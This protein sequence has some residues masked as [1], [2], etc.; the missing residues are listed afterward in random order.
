M[1]PNGTIDYALNHIIYGIIYLFSDLQLKKKLY[2]S[3][4]V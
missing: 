3:I 1:V 4:S 2:R